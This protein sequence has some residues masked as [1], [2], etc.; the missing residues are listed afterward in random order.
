M[1]H[2]IRA[3]LLKLRTT[4]MLPLNALAA[5]AFVPISVATSISVAGDPGAGP[6]LTTSDGV[7]NVMSAASSGSLVILLLGIMVMAGEFRHNTATSTFLISPNRSQVVRAKLIAA[8]IVGLLLALAS[9][10]LTLVLALPWLASKD[11]DVNI[12]G[13]VVPILLGG[14][15]A[16]ALYALVGVGVGSMVRNQ[17]TAVAGALLWAVVAEG[18]LV[19]LAPDVGRWLP[20]GAAAALSGVATANGGLLPIWGAAL[21][22]TAYGLTFAAA[23]TRLLLHRD[24]T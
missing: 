17:T 1:N 5:L 7:R 13:D 14:T 15:A 4:R 19:S 6:A 12:L 24:I 16:T 9:A 10:A 23:G 3:E 18:L 21:L 11:I 2:L 8:S 20:G 22:L